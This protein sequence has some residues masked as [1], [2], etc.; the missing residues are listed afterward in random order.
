MIGF[1]IFN[2]ICFLISAIYI[3]KI[4]YFYDYRYIG[5]IIRFIIVYCIFGKI[6]FGGLLDHVADFNEVLMIYSI[7]SFIV[8]FIICFLFRKFLVNK[9]GKEERFANSEEV[10][11][12]GSLKE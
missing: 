10:D 9:F 2:I 4:S 7:S 5:N 6:I 8:C 3:Y 1:W 11:N 12:I